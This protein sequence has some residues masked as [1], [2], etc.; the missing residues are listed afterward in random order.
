ML[1]FGVY[2]VVLTFLLFLFYKLKCLLYLD[3]EFRWLESSRSLEDCVAYRAVFWRE[4]LDYEKAGLGSR[5]MEEVDLTRAVAV[6]S[7]V[8]FLSQV[9]LF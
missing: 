4:E 9:R 3:F 1:V 7:F 6:V 5:A 8:S 2:V